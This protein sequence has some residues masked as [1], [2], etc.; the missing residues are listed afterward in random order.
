MKIKEL[1]TIEDFES[2]RKGDFVAC[3]FNRDI[4]DYP[5]KYR[6]NVFRVYD[7]LTKTKEVVL[8]KKNN[9]Y[10]NYQLFIENRSILKS[11]ILITPETYK[12]EGGEE[13]FEGGKITRL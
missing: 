11:A 1:K 7:V 5:K 4:H 6:F 12:I 10:F 2:L 8:Q 9:I 3:E 13:A